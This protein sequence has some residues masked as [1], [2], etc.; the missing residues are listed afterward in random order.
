MGKMW[1]HIAAMDETLMGDY[2]AMVQQKTTDK[3]ALKIFEKEAQELAASGEILYQL[4]HRIVA[5]IDKN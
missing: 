2:G 3:P 4:H 1:H 5:A